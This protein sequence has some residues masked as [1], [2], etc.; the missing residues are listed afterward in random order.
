VINAIFLLLT[1]TVS[2]AGDPSANRAVAFY[3]F[4][5]AQQA[6]FRR[7]VVTALAE[8]RK[9]RDI[10]PGSGE[11]HAHIAQLLWETGKLEES[12]KEAEEAVRVEPG[13]AKAQL[14]LA[15]S[16]SSWGGADADALRKAAQA[17]EEYARLEPMDVEA[18]AHLADIY[19]RIEDH[20]SAVFAW[21]R[22]IELMP[23]NLEAYLRLGQHL[24]ALKETERAEKILA[25]A[26][27][28]DPESLSAYL[29][30]ADIYAQAEQSAEA[31]AVMRKALEIDPDNVR[32]RLHL[33][34]MLFYADRHAEASSEAD[35]VLRIDPSNRYALGIKGQALRESNDLTGAEDAVTR[36]LARYPSEILGLY[37]KVTIEE[38][39]H[40]WAAAAAAIE[41]A[42][43]RKRDGEQLDQT[44]QADRRFLVH[45][46]FA[47]QQLGRQ[48]DAA[49]AFARALKIGEYDPRLAAQEVDAWIR[50][51]DLETALARARAASGL[52]PDDAGLAALEA[53]VLFKRG[54]TS[55]AGSIIE[56]LLQRGGEDAATLLEA[57]G[58]YRR[59][60]ELDR[61]EEIL[62]QALAIEPQ[63]L[64]TL[65]QLG[66]VLERQRRFDEAEEVFRAALAIEPDAAVVL[67]YI[68][69]MN[70]DRGVRV[71]EALALIEKALA[72]DPENGAY[73]D[74]LGWALYR[75]GRLEEAERHIRRAISKTGRNAVVLDHLG[76][77]LIKRG[78]A[79]DAVESWRQALNGDDEEQELNRL[80]V[81]R[82]IQDVLQSLDESQS[83]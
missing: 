79:R 39:R 29:S 32:V 43:A 42:L 68:G 20:K 50:A 27:E 74:S 52:S 26:L 13:S 15:Q 51:D 33:A 2:N 44:N 8:L 17:Y 66:S 7:D 69:Y 31:I 73:L 59:I 16:L 40:D 61:A 76:D 60:R 12:L 9:A 56:R 38:A 28:L 22:L 64:V 62:R 6:I 23:D 82:K 81:E 1:L 53:E 70:A 37:L 72:I 41:A 77:V 5:L 65:L 4:C 18:L 19:R 80:H 63:R 46:G 21:E 11:I 49:K 14:V 10:D 78:R 24:L 75:L 54:D 36:L 48:A 45:L 58:Y 47:Y 35:E 30:L 67:N 71:E 3:H 55:A 25:R 83:P 57:A 34:E